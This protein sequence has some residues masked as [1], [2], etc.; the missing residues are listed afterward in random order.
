MKCIIIL[1][2]KSSGSSACQNLLSK[3]A[4]VNNIT[5][6][7]HFENE[8]LYWTKAASIL[9]MPQRKMLDSEVPI[10]KAKAQADLITLLS[11]NLDSFDPSANADDL[12]FGG[13]K[14]LCQRFSPIFLEKSPHHLLQWSALQLIAECMNRYTEIDFLLIG[15][16]R[17]PMDTLYSS[18]KRWKTIPEKGQYEW[19]IAYQN[20]LRF[21]ELV[22]DKLYIIRYEDMVSDIDVLRPVLKFMGVDNPKDSLYSNYLHN[23]SIAKWKADKFYG[24]NLDNEVSRL[25]QDYG[26]TNDDLANHNTILW[27]FYRSLSRAGYKLLAPAFPIIDKLRR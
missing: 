1:S 5:K 15:L 10:D 14:L 25:A 24:F 26:Y 2:N 6:T 22:G 27:P 18:F 20:L 17:N 12:I 23:K 7:R 16:V 4:E 8:T 21:K 9:E 13:W 11:D 19:L 3:S